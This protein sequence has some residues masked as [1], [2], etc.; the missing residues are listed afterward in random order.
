MSKSRMWS[1][2]T[3]AGLLASVMVVG[4]MTL[5]GG[6]T[7]ASA[8]PLSEPSV[9][10]DSPSD[11][12]GPR[13][14]ELL[15]EAKSKGEKNVMLLIATDKG[16]SADV[17]AELKKLG[18]KIAKR[19]DEIGYVRASVPTSA[20]LAAASVAGITAVDLDD[21]VQLPKPEPV[22]ARAS[23]RAQATVAGPGPDTP[24]AN[25]YMPTSEIGAVSFKESHPTWDGRGVTIG[26]MDTG[27]DLDHPSLQTTSTGERKIVDWFTATDP[28]FDGDLTWRIM[29]D[30]VTGP[31][32]SYAGATWTAPAGA[33]KINR[34]SESITAASSPAGDV[35]RDGDRTDQFGILYDP[36]T[37]NIRVDANQNR[38]FTDDPVMRPYAER[39][40][41]GHFGTDNPGTA[42]REQMPFVVEFREDVDTTPANLPG[43]YDF[44]NIGIVEA[45]H[46]SHVAGITAGN[47][48]F[49]GSMSG[50][51]PGAKLVSVRACLFVTGCTDH[52]LVE[53]MIYAARD[54]NVDVI[55]M[56]IGGLPWVN[57]GNNARA[58]IYNRLIDEFDVQMYISA[59]NEG[60]GMNTVGDPSVVDKVVSVGS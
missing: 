20:V 48:L 46:G 28:I 31:S 17:A 60:A 3:S 2:R 34:F 39:Y 49:G 36:A 27:V 47:S 40:D 41:T 7:T 45:A 6:A 21:T 53:G 59:G 8:V 51:A 56:S 32:F 37:N 54:A 4:A 26:I 35:N 38:D 58:V 13:D 33:Y 14:L 18:G 30:G 44:V 25:P 19:V 15:A 16:E 43:T 5:A 55:N 52:A 23:A 29:R 57:D 11:T 22:P 50:A 12:L 10:K 24:A 42:V 9:L 1:R